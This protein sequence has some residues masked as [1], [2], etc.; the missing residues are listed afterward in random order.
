M[1]GRIQRPAPIFLAAVAL[2]VLGDVLLRKTP[3][4]INLTVWTTAL[5]ATLFWI[6]MSENSDIRPRGLFLPPVLFGACFAWRSAELLA[7]CNFLALLT[8]LGLSAHQTRCLASV[9]VAGWKKQ[10]APSEIEANV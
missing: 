9:A 2:G 6:S 7:Y 4:G 10:G 3:W 5:T 1:S 8:T